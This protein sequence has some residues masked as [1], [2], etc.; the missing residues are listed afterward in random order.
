MG[1]HSIVVLLATF[2]TATASFAED[3]IKVLV[4]QKGNWETSVPDLGQRKG[5]FAK[6]GLKIDTLYTSGGGETIGAD[7]RE[8]RH[9]HLDRHRR[10]LECLRQ[11]CPHTS[12]SSLHDRG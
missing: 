4:P 11:G 8:R 7:F 5:I 10:D 3:T 6:H 12:D 9:C 1:L 2:I